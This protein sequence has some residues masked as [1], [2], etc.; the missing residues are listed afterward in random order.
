MQAERFV[1]FINRIDEMQKHLRRIRAALGT[2]LDMKGVHTLWVYLLYLHPE[3]LTSAEIA[4]LCSVDRSLVSREI[5][6]LRE[7]G[8]VDMKDQNGRRAYNSTVRLTEK[9]MA[10]AKE[11]GRDAMEIQKCVDDGITDEE[12]NVFYTTVEK[13]C[14]N[15]EKLDNIRTDKETDDEA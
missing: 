14:R 10:L 2:A 3:G 12:L 7:N 15:F 11:I 1:M 9:G 8:I 6:M 13:I 5:N 4:E